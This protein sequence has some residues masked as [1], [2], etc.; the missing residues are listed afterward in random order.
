MG[1][2]V[3][4]EKIP[5]LTSMIGTKAQRYF[6]ELGF[7]ENLKRPLTPSYHLQF[8]KA[9][10][11]FANNL[12]GKIVEHYHG[13]LIY[14]GGDDV[15][16][17]VPA[18]KAI[19]CS[20]A[21]RAV[22]RGDKTNLPELESKYHLAINHKGFV[23]VGDD[24]EYLVPGPEAE[25]SC[26]IA[27]GHC[28]HPLQQIVNEARLA[29]KR[30]KS[31]YGRAAFSISLLKRGGETIHWGAKW[32]SCAIE[33]YENYMTDQQKGDKAIIS[34]RFPYAVAEFFKPYKLES[35]RETNSFI[36]CSLEELA[37]ILKTELKH[38]AEQQKGK[39]ILK[40][41]NSYLDELATGIKNSHNEN[42]IRL[43]DFVNLFLTAAFVKRE[44]GE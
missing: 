9:L 16:A 18:D 30:A 40:E 32:N 5:T 38:V 19:Y 35:H 1:K 36:D 26:G 37:N 13:Q 8:S 20:R 27:I 42:K 24:M 25:V 33:L 23:A 4:G 28:Q 22:F 43:D 10:A 21:L 6:K 11:N 14:A 2:W 3:S 29:E 7:D 34:G 12:A 44:R 41:C 17:M 31:E 15:L 39:S